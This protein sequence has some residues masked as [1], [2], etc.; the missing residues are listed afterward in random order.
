MIVWQVDSKRNRRNASSPG[1][2]QLSGFGG[3]W[4]S[5]SITLSRVYWRQGI[6]ICITGCAAAQALC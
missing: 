1:I 2:R 6:L 5:A 4:R 3:D